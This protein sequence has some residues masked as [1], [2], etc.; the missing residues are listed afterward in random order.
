M[1]DGD[2]RIEVL[3]DE[4]KVLKGEV[5]R[6]LVD[7]RALLMRDDSPLMTGGGLVSRIV[8][9][10]ESSAPTQVSMAPVAAEIVPTVAAITPPS[11]LD[12]VSPALAGLPGLATMAMPD[13][14]GVPDEGLIH[15]LESQLA[16]PAPE[17]QPP[18]SAP[19]TGELNQ[20]FVG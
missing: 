10:E 9:Q 13:L 16:P 20:S 8:A 11:A 12:V 3:E 15:S 1:A 5:S 2:Q 18:P 4:M 17:T 6:T 7:L 19:S 14:P